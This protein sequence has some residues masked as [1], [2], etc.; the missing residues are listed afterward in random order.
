[1]DREIITKAAFILLGTVGTCWAGCCVKS[2]EPQCSKVVKPDRVDKVLEQLKQKTETLESYQAGVEYLFK[3][4]APFDSQTLK[5]GV[6]YYQQFGGKSKLRMNFQTLKQDNEKQQKYV[7]QFIFDGVWLTV[8]DYQIKQVTKE[9]LAEPNKPMDAF[10]LARR[11]FPIIG[12]TK[13]EELKRDFVMKLVEQKESGKE[14]FVQLHLKVKPD[15]V[16][17]DDYTAVDFWVDKK[18]GLP[19]KIVAVSTEDDIYEIKLLKPRVNKKIS[20]KVFDFKVPKGFTAKETPL[21]KGEKT[22]DTRQKTQ[23]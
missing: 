2:R 13:V 20:K 16:Y 7:E 6:L 5:K 9:Q 12:F 10:E 8:I 11:V 17:K 3:Q 22:T 21:K 18:L 19:A 4:P 1:M 15:S 23:D 14:A